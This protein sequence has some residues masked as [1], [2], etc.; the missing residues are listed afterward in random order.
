[1]RRVFQVGERGQ[2]GQG[3]P[4]ISP[5]PLKGALGSRKV[6]GKLRELHLHVEA[7]PH[8]P[9]HHHPLHRLDTAGTETQ[10]GFWGLCFLEED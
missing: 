5:G 4:E 3:G 1:M 8:P 10:T 9:K 7:S 2:K 6:T